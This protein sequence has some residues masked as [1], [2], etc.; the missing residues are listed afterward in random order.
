ME[1]RWPCWFSC[2]SCISES[3]FWPSVLEPLTRFLIL[4]VV[5]ICPP[6]SNQN[7]LQ[8]RTRSPHRA[9]KSP[10][11]RRPDRGGL[12]IRALGSAWAFLLDSIRFLAVAA[13][14]MRLPDPPVPSACEMNQ[15]MM[16]SIAEGLQSVKAEVALRWLMLV[17]ASLNFALAG[18]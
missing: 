8:R 17:I 13:A 5:P 9:C 18:S 3:F 12:F 6:P 2:Q 14:L 4:L 15:G 11:G 1:P 10:R 7:S 16:Q